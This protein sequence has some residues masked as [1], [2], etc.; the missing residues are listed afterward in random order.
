MKLIQSDRISNRGMQQ[1]AKPPSQ[2]VFRINF[3]LFWVTSILSIPIDYFRLTQKI[4]QKSDAFWVL[5]LFKIELLASVVL[6]A[7]VLVGLVRQRR[8]RFDAFS[9]FAWVLFLWGAGNGIVH[10][11]MEDPEYAWHFWASILFAGVMAPVLYQAF[12][13]GDFEDI[14]WMMRYFE[15]YAKSMLWVAAALFV[16]FS[17]RFQSTRGLNW[18]FTVPLVLPFIW[19]VARRRYVLALVCAGLIVINGKRGITLWLVCAGV[20]MVCVSL[21]NASGRWRSRSFA[22]LTL[23]TLSGGAAVYYVSSHDLD[24]LPV[25]I[26][27]TV[28]KWELLTT[29]DKS[30]QYNMEMA[31]SGRTSELRD[32]FVVFSPVTP[33]WLI[34]TG[35]GWWFWSRGITG[36]GT[37]PV[38]LHYVHFSPADILFQ[39]GLPLALVFFLILGVKVGRA[40]WALAKNAEH[41]T[42]DL[43]LILY[44]VSALVGGVTGYTY[45]TD[46]LIWIGAGAAVRRHR[47]MRNQR[48]VRVGWTGA[49]E[50]VLA[51]TRSQD[52]KKRQ[53]V[54]SQSGATPL[55]R[56][57]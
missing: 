19:Y 25:G 44:S 57:V 13:S 38:Q 32:A 50:K 41:V 37:K 6:G 9:G 23:L 18:G 39:Y 55:A 53:H 24:E 34:G 51:L 15:F 54:S 27:G 46:P 20:L 26:R 16:A 36:V 3:V 42:V 29:P 11:L 43:V 30:G 28:Y 10:L 45:G 22:C 8:L 17:V 47:I 21:A 56:R 2:R 1:M 7:W 35:Y 52:L 14:R 5:Q 12:S 49:A 31:S 33:N 48:R 4:S 40:F